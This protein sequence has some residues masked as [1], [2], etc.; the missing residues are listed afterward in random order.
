MFLS[1]LNESYKIYIYASE[2]FAH[3]SYT[4]IL[5]LEPDL[6]SCEFILLFIPVKKYVH[7]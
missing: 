5:W 3:E 4:T 2:P 1:I 6:W 7:G